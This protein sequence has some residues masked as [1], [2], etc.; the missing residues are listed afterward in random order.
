MRANPAPRF[1]PRQSTRPPGPRGRP[2]R[3]VLPETQTL[4]GARSL[5]AGARSE[6]PAGNSEPE[7]RSSRRKRDRREGMPPARGTAAPRP[8]LAHMSR[9]QAKL[10][11]H[12][13]GASQAQQGAGALSLLDVRQYAF[14]L[15]QAVVA[16]HQLAFSVG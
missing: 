8:R 7:H 2:K 6:G 15:I 16:D 14:Q 1:P 10:P 12:Y 9:R 4:Q 5:L 11:R 3:L 13:R